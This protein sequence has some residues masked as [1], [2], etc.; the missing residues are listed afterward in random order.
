MENI[1]LQFLERMASVDLS[2]MTSPYIPRT[3]TI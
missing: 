3:F 2:S 1:E